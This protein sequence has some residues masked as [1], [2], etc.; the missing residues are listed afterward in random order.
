VIG[1]LHISDVEDRARALGESSIP[2]DV[3]RRDLLDLL[4]QS[5]FITDEVERSA[6]VKENSVKRIDRDE[7]DALEAMIARARQAK[8]GK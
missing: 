3:A 5:F 7:L 6:L 4:D 8:E 2:V 1:E